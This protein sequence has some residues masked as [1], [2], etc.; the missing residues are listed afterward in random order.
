MSGT[1]LGWEIGG[2]VRGRRLEDAAGVCT[3]TLSQ[4][5]HQA[6]QL[7]HAVHVARVAQV[8]QADISAATGPQVQT[9]DF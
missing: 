7:Q 3:V 4:A 8:G 1:D 2:W 5:G 9:S 6:Q